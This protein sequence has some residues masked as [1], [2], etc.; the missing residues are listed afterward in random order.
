MRGGRCGA[1]IALRLGEVMLQALLFDLDGTLAHTDPIH[2]EV[3]CDILREF[4]HTLTPDL[5]NSRISGRLNDAIIR[6]WLPHLSD[7]EGRAL[8]DRKEAEFRTRAETRLQPMPGLNELLDW[9][10]QQPLKLGMVTNAPRDN[11]EFML[12]VLH[13]TEVFETVVLADELERGK[14]DPLPYE[15]AIAQL[16]VRALDSLVF[17][18]SPSGI[19]AA[20]AAGIPTVGITSSHDAE[21]LRQLGATWTA[22]DFADKGVWSLVRSRHGDSS[23]DET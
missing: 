15:V 4:D 14:P 9:A 7:A 1:G 8:S 21:K 2:Y 23:A 3:W 16:G 11:A 17:E 5:Y 18:D 13:L 10:A 20:V 22:P 12:R 19:K 6:D